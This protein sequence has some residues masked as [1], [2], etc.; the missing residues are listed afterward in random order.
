MMSFKYVNINV[1]LG[2]FSFDV[3]IMF[4]DKLV[5]ADVAAVMVAVVRRSFPGAK[6]VEVVSAGEL[7]CLEVDGTHGGSSTLHVG[8]RPD[9]ERMINSYDYAHG[10]CR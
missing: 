10:V 8:S 9:D 7:G 4:P 2:E 1:R 6:S 5:H 3:P